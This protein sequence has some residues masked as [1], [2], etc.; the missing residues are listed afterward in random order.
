MTREDKSFC[1]QSFWSVTPS[2]P[3]VQES[4]DVCKCQLPSVQF[5]CQSLELELFNSINVSFSILG[6]LA[7]QFCEYWLLSS[8]KVKFSC[9][10]C[11][12]LVCKCQLRSSVNVT[13]LPLQTSSLQLCK[14]QLLNCANIVFD[15]P[16][17]SFL[18]PH[19]LFSQTFSRSVYSLINGSRLTYPTPAGYL[20]LATRINRNSQQIL[21]SD[22]S[23]IT[24]NMCH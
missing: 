9:L 14:C 15:S 4:G 19:S 23:L 20:R 13:S 6:M 8:D 2:A 1:R 12:F 21:A 24:Q 3:F 5:S 16:N 17:I 10:E 18:T 7:L 22:M 11:Q